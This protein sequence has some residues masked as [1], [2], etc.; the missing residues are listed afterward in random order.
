MI[1]LLACLLA[2]LAWPGLASKAQA[3]ERLVS[4]APSLSEIVLELEAA[5]LL[6]GMLDGGE[7]PPALAEVPSVGR[8]GQL[9]MESLLRLQPDL[10]LLWPD[11]IGP[12]Q[13]QQLL[14]FGI[15]LLIVEPRDLATLA[16]QFAEIGRRIGRAEQGRQLRQRFGTRLHGLATRYRRERP[17]RVF[18]Q[19]WDK[20]LY[21]IGGRQ[22]ISDA[23]RVCGAENVFA[24][25]SLPAPQVS[26]E[27][28]L[29]RDPEVILAGSGAQLDIWK[30]WPDLA[31][32][33]LDQLWAV[34]DKGLERPSFQMLDAT[35]QLCE[36]LAAAQ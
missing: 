35:E 16:E 14:D 20:P 2:L 26:I 24:D 12:A 23:L 29:Q 5:D 6:V 32:V 30:H 21:T 22:I 7:R 15:P 10:V 3:V 31:A 4:L 36:R 28:V 9:E 8:Y 19:I 17:L 1:R 18:Y 34:P 11:S 25:L 13:R 33:R 27:A